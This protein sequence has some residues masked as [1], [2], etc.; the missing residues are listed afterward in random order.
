M[1]DFEPDLGLK[2]FVCI[3]PDFSA[4]ICTEHAKI[5]VNR[6]C[7][8]FFSFFHDRSVTYCL[9]SLA[10]SFAKW[11]GNGDIKEVF[12][13]CIDLITLIKLKSDIV[14]FLYSASGL[15]A[16]TMLQKCSE[17]KQL[18]SSESV[19]SSIESLKNTSSKSRKRLVSNEDSSQRTSEN[20]ESFEYSL[21]SLSQ[22]SIDGALV[23]DNTLITEEN[24]AGNET[25]LKAE[26]D[27]PE[28]HTPEGNFKQFEMPTAKL[29]LLFK[30]QESQLNSTS[31]FSVDGE[32]VPAY[33]NDF[34]QIK[35]SDSNFC[36]QCQKCVIT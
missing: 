34:F 31:P 29:M 25:E 35:P 16:R 36:Y 30:L 1:F 11:D 8:G 3:F 18:F 12:E 5:A 6:V 7:D 32:K 33:L 9:V 4:L 14:G 23:S 27:Y 10:I 19:Q 24:K 13:S 20:S 28:P 17:A 22:E 26:Y 2:Q 21:T 15:T